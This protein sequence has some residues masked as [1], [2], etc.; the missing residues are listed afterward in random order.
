MKVL[1]ITYYWPPAG[2]S[3]VQRWLYFVKY[4]R[5]YGIEPVVFT[6][7]NPSYPIFDESLEAHI[8]TNVEVIRQKIWEPN[9]ILSKKNKKTGAGFLQQNPSIIQ[10]IAHYIRANFFIPDA[11]KFWIKPA[12]K[13]LTN[14]LDK[15][16]VDW[17]ITTGPP[18]S[19]HLIGNT[20]QQK[21]SI[22]WLAD[23]RDP[24]T[25]IDYFHQ[26]P[27]TKNSLKKHQTLEKEV[28]SNADIVTVVGKSMQEKYLRFNENCKV[29]T[30]GF[31]S[32]SNQEEFATLD[33]TFSLTHI[34]ML[35]ADRNPLIF[36]K[37]IRA[38]LDKNPEFERKLQINL[39]G[40]VADAVLAS[41]KKYKLE[42][43]I[44]Y[45]NY[46]SHDSVIEHQKKSQVL[47]LF[48]NQVPS[49]K[50][51]ITG[52]VFEYLQAKR[53]I[54][55]IAP[56]DGDLADIIE[57]TKSGKLIGFNDTSSLKK[58]LLSYFDAYVKGE[59][60]IESQNIDIYTRKNLTAQLADLLKT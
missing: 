27:L 23:F 12:V 19:V 15:N 21:T 42:K 30:N 3:G 22:K 56:T 35:N 44:H 4:L 18:H 28:L 25:E 49:A 59:L 34:G 26:L 55:A 5:E 17:I 47:L 57:K 29:I 6:V 39:I 13:K 45:T 52:K 53:P 43:Y 40:N 58:Q 41:I 16:P 1:I 54:L 11:R 36:W 38:L 20:L 48:I 32:N 9:T 51:I 31:D 14:Y 24:W 50:G 33:T 8:P 37:T 46:I 2:G 60:S 10:K 7:E